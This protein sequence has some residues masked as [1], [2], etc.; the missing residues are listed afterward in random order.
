MQ[1]VLER[2]FYISGLTFS[3]IYDILLLQKVKEEK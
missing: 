1:L 3:L 2:R